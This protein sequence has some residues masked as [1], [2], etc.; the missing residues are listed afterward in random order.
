MEASIMSTADQLLPLIFSWIEKRERCADQLI[1]LARELES[2][3]E[4]CN[5]G[6]CVGSSVAVLGAACV[7]G[8]GLATLFTGG[9]AAPFL[10]MA[11]AAYTGVGIT[12]SVAAKITENFLSSDTMKEA[13]KIEEKSNKTA[14]EIQQLFDKLR[15]E[16]KA[17]NP[18]ADPDELDRHITSKILTSMARRSG[19]KGEVSI[20][21]FND[22]PEI[23]LNGRPR[24]S[25]VNDILA[26]QAMFGVAGV[27]SFFTFQ[28]SGK[29]F[30]LLF[31]EGV[32]QLVKQMSTTAFKTALKGG[33]KVVG[34]AVGMVFAL[35]E[36]I[37][38]WTDMIKKNH[39]TEASQSLRDT[40]NSIRKATQTLRKQ[41]DSIKKML[42]EMA[43]Y[44]QEQEEKEKKKKRKAKVF[45]VVTVQSNSSADDSHGN[46]EAHQRRQTDE[47][48]QEGGRCERSSRKEQ[49]S[50]RSEKPGGQQPGGG[51]PGGK[52][53]DSE[54][55]DG[56]RTDEENDSDEDSS[57]KKIIKKLSRFLRMGL[58]NARSI[59]NKL[60]PISAL[61]KKY[62]L[63]VLFLTETWLRPDTG[64]DILRR[65][66]PDFQFEQQARETPGG[67]VAVLS[68][69]KLKLKAKQ[70]S[71]SSNTSFEYVVASIHHETWNQPI[72]TI[73]LYRRPRYNVTRFL[74]ELK[75]L[76]N[77]FSNYNSILV[78]GDFNIW[79]DVQTKKPVR[80]F[81][82]FLE[83]NGLLQHVEEPT[84][85]SGHTLDLVISRNI[86]IS[87]LYVS[88][89]RISDHYTI[90][91]SVRPL[92]SEEE[93]EGRKRIKTIRKKEED[94]RQIK[95]R[96]E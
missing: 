87:N 54:D 20:G 19:V 77:N 73:T 3:R 38:N 92:S 12:V 86:K 46:N 71:S 4:K 33:A 61:I 8:A 22:K 51:D 76:L 9:A 42:D 64:D 62:K 96:E 84:Y 29:E 14:A 89:E 94:K 88:G 24:R 10:G 91:F 75:R 57:N 17:E 55:E 82:E 58:L 68:L 78:T 72:L 49:G 28:L 81:I 79:V 69:G 63:Q 37:D 52:K 56:S 47:N 7:I 45:F 43:K 6:E 80:R 15:A 5:A 48:Y 18:S 34:G 13:K 11:G 90:L 36:A 74:E 39:V 1:K 67:G 44:Q 65:S 66:F 30:Q 53:S 59:M 41:L 95:K 16:A 27:L 50:G 40:A 21:F 32:K 60:L 35:Q 2:L 93:E 31:A 85:Y 23:F 25:G 70:T 26:S 83:N